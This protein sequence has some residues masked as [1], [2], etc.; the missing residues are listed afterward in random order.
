MIKPSKDVVFADERIKKAWGDI[1]RNDE[2]MAKQLN[3]AREDLLADAFYGRPVRK[4]LIPK[5]YIQKYEID[6]LWIYNLPNGWRLLYTLIPENKI[7]IITII[8]DWMPHKD[9]ERLFDF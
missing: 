7:E 8:L 2:V 3:R 6:N 1:K 9:Y 4:K 5:A